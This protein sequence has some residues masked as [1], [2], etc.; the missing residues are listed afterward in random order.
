ME[1]GGKITSPLPM[2]SHARC[3]WKWKDGALK[4]NFTMKI[5]CVI[6]I[7]FRRD[8]QGGRF[9][10]KA[11]CSVN[12]ERK[13]GLG[14]FPQHEALFDGGEKLFVGNGFDK[15]EIDLG[16]TYSLLD[17]LGSVFRYYNDR[18]MFYT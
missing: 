8:Y 16:C 13:K 6:E 15:K 9:T 12:P 1:R 18:R 7:F 2:A 17:L 4:T 3:R 11:L 10:S 5:R 14:Y